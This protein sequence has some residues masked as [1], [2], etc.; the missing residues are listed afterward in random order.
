MAEKKV[1]LYGVWGSPFSKRVEL[2]LKMKGVEYELFEEDIVNNNKSPEL[3]RYNPVHKK[4]PV[5]VHGDHPIA[6]S[7]VIIEYIDETWDSGTPIFPRDPYQKALARF[8]A[9]FIDDKLLP[10]IFKAFWQGDEQAMEEVVENMKILDKELEGKRFF[11][12]ESVGFVDVVG[13][14]LGHWFAAMEE[15]TGKVVVTQEAFPWVCK[16][17]DELSKC[18]V[19]RETVPPMDKLV[20]FLG[21][22]IQATRAL[23]SARLTYD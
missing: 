4:I 9:R 23:A 15:A 14:I 7:Q 11:G 13:I 19:V 21:P 10:S 16:W 8:W 17:R 12:G 1:K 22:R 18:K 6:E 2:A 20:A 5:L 3:L